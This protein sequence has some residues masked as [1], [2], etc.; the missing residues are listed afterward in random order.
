M[1]LVQR[2][3]SHTV[4]KSADALMTIIN[5]ILDFS[6]IE[7]GRLRLEPV[8]STSWSPSRRWASC[9]RA[10]LRRR[11][12]SHRPGRP[13]LPRHLVGDPGRI[14]QILINLVGKP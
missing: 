11:S 5:D 8:P 12:R 3:Y 7:A 10:R 14:R 6:K 9:S 1:T 4:R 2:H 13:E